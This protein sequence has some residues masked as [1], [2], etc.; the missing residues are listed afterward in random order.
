MH[1]ILA[2]IQDWRQAGK[3]IAIATVVKAQGSSLRPMGAKM[4]M[5]STREISGSVSGGCVEGA[6]YEEAQ[7]VIQDGQPRLL[8]YGVS[9]NAAWEVGLA[10]GGSIQVFVESLESPP[11]QQVYESIADCLETRQLMAAATVV[12]GP[13]LGK[14]ILLWSKSPAQGD[15]GSP[16]INRAAMVDIQRQIGAQ[17]PGRFSYPTPEGGV[18]VFVDVF[19]PPPR[20]VVIGAVHIAIH[21]VSLAKI[22]GYYTIIIDPRSAF[23]TRERFPHADELIVEW[24]STAI[25]RLQPD[26]ATYLACL[27]HDEKL[28]NPALEVALARPTRY[29]GALGSRRTHAKRV[30]DLQE[31][32]VAEE[33]L[34]RIH[35]PIGLKLGAKYPEEIALEIMA[36]V[37]AARHELQV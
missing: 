5:T 32:G 35:A 31:L 12:A 22:L 25:E 19:A 26:E 10:C 36:E 34:K 29:V 14:K 33:Q 27:S 1:E 24:P 20:L 11:W 7:R 28:D 13:G 15:L 21:L 23:A 8:E 37:Q 6:V 3:Q 16:E 30:Q 2:D 4:A 18:E 17:E 9:D